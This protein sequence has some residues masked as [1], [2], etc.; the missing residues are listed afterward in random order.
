MSRPPG[1]E[2][3]AVV[4][5]S[6]Q[7]H[8]GGAIERRFSASE[9]PR[10]SEAG[11][12]EPGEVRVSIRFST[13]EGR[14]AMDGALTGTVTMTCQRC[15]QPAAVDVEDQFRLLIVDEEA[16]LTAE[17][18]GFEPVVA[19]PARLDLRWV[20]EEQMLLSVPLVAKH[21]DD[22]CA[23]GSVSEGKNEEPVVQR[24]FANL[25]NLLREQ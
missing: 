12:S 17:S 11:I 8:R 20:A 14:V 23:S 22:S 19:D 15:M 9:L 24:P 6:V 21:A 5:A 10:L 3:D 13:Y 18:G 16:D 25:R 7:A 1:V 2:I 4:D